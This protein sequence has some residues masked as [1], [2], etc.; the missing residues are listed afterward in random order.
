[1]SATLVGIVPSLGVTGT[2]RSD[3]STNFT[4]F[5]YS[6]S[7]SLVHFLAR[8]VSVSNILGCKNRNGR[9]KLTIGA[10]R[11]GWTLALRAKAGSQ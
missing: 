9:K 8:P 1:M 11:K 4:L 10:I 7:V 5:G 3:L 2:V 6:I